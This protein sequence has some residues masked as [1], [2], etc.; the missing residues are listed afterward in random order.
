MAFY[1]PVESTFYSWCVERLLT[2]AEL[3]P[4]IADGVAELGA[5]TGIPVL[6]AVGRSETSAHIRGFEND[7][8]AFRAARRLLEL[9]GPANYTI[10]PDDFFEYA[11]SARERC[12]IANPP[13]LPGIPGSGA[14]VLYGGDRGAQ[15]SRRLLACSF[16]AVMLMVSSISDPLGVLDEA[17]HRGYRV[18][19]WS[20][21]PISFG[22]YCHDDAVW[23]RIQELG[24]RGAAFFEP[25]EYLLAGVTWVRD[26][27]VADPPGR[28]A[29]T[30]A[31]VLTAGAGMVAR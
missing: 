13:Y 18:I 3:R 22:R 10:A 4:Y 19:D 21:R 30:L 25:E 16:D 31:R 20:V 9:K 8:E 29:A 12:V 7:P 11:T 2:T 5:G 23:R 15:V 14:P 24:A 27:R 1:D 17:A 6:D 26:G 28:D